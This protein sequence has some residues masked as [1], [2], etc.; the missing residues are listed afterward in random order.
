[1]AT[2]NP[3]SQVL[4]TSGNQAIL[5]PGLRV[6]SLK[7]GQIGIFNYHTGLSVNGSVLGDCQDIFIALGINR[8]SGGTA[9]MEDL[10]KSAGQVIQARNTK[11]IT[12]KG[13]VVE[14]PKIV[15]VSGYSAKCDTDYILK[16]EFRSVAA[17]MTNGYN[18]V[19]K[20]YAYHTACCADECAD[21]PTG[22]CTELAAGLAAAINADPDK[23][24]TASLLSNQIVTTVTGP[25]SATGS[26]GFTVGAE[27]FTAAVT[28]A[29]TATV[30]ATAMKNAINA[31]STSNFR[32]TSSGAVLTIR[33]KSGNSTNTETIVITAP[34]TGVA[35]TGTALTNQ[36]VTDI[37]TF[38]TTYPG[39]C[40][41]LRLTGT[42]EVRPTFGQIN[43]KYH[44]TGMNFIVSLS[45]GFICN[46][47]VTVFQEL[48]YLEGSGY[49]LKQEE[50]VAGGQNGN[51]GVY[52]I[53]MSTG[54][55]KNIE[56]LAVESAMYN[57][58]A[59]AYDQFS[60]GGWLEYLNNLRTVI[61][62]PCAD[63]ATLTGLIGVLDLI[64]ANRFGAL[65]DDVS[66]MDCTNTRTGLLLPATDG[67]ESLA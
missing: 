15:D 19:T 67:I 5:G 55:P 57:T 45:E 7:N 26:L 12:V 44:K 60:V 46:G 18:N 8:T 59:L 34:V 63:S 33:K 9:N 58:V 39:A 2:E 36:V 38:K 42:S 28:S 6:D 23:L 31:V 24:L 50:Y 13:H 49:D 14:I 37:P 53:T 1:M 52:R 62:I 40:L 47:V 41:N 21:C 66:A 56:Y 3:V 48:Q 10:R 35:L 11:S 22:D 16:V 51:P 20:S 64:F 29:D 25:A 32:A 4:V 27:A 17:Y 54:F 43:V 65:T 61:G 30:I